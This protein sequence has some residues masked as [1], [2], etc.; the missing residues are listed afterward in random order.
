[1]VQIQVTRKLGGSFATKSANETYQ[2]VLAALPEAGFTIW[3]R[4]DIAWLVMVRCGEAVDGN[5][6]ARPGGQVIASLSSS[7][8]DEA[9]LR[10]LAERLFQQLEGGA[11]G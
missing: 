3:K 9:E 11:Q 7:H 5:V 8:R 1:M 4:R 2:A 10:A 6:S